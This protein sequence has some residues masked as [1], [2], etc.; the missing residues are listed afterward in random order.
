[1][2]KELKYKLIAGLFTTLNSGFIYY[3]IESKDAEVVTN[4]NTLTNLIGALEKI[5][6]YSFIY[7]LPIIFIIG[8]PIS[9]LIDFILKKVSLDKSIISFIIHVSIFGIGI[10]LYWGITLGLNKINF[11][12]EPE[13]VYNLF[14][15]VYTPG[16]FWL[17]NYMQKKIIP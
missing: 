8:I 3:L 14:I 15:F 9:I 2:I 5:L 17:I 12:S 1:M 11:M 10:I 6:A 4:K 16:I 7:V 13:L